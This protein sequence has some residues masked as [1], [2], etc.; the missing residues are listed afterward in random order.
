M[1]SAILLTRRNGAVVLHAPSFGVTV[2]SG[3]SWGK[4][5]SGNL[6]LLR[7]ERELQRRMNR[8]IQMASLAVLAELAACEALRCCNGSDRC[9]VGGLS[10][11]R[12]LGRPAGAGRK[13]RG[14]R[15]PV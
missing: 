13:P 3:Y 6:A 10:S 14:P 9:A 5:R 2:Q 4:A 8:T 1:N 15:N 11:E 12:P 7:S